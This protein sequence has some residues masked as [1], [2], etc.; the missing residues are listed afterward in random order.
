MGQKL[1]LEQRMEILETQM[2]D[3]TVMYTRMDRQISERI[4]AVDFVIARIY[5]EFEKTKKAKKS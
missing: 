1:T 4:G 2:R 3:L 5:D